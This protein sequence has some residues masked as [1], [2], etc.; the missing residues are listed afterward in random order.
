MIYMLFTAMHA[1]RSHTQIKRMEN[2]T[3]ETK[4]EK[5]KNVFAHDWITHGAQGTTRYAH[6]A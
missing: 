6:I 5:K 1:H 3:K 4:N 2:K